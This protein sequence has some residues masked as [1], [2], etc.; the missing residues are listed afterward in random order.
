MLERPRVQD[1]DLYQ[2]R[3]HAQPAGNV[4]LQNGGPQ[5]G[6]VGRGQGIR[7]LAGG[8]P[9]VV[10]WSWRAAPAAALPPG[11]GA[12]MCEIFIRASEQSYAPETR[13]GRDRRARQHARH[14][15]DRTP[16]RR[17]DR[18][19]RRGRQLHIVPARVLPALSAAAG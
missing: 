5:P 9:N 6:G 13:P 12:P 11:T 18:I 10:Q 1:H 2:P 15:T 8:A 16:V 4:W 7:R 19:P 14:A 17:A 3:R